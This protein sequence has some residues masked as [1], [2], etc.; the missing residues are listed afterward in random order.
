MLQITVLKK[1]HLLQEMYITITTLELLV[2]TWRLCL[3]EI[4]EE[5]HLKLSDYLNQILG[6]L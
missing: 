2:S 4:R 3:T 1:V 6:P 5:K